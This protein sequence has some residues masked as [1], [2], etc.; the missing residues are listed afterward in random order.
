[1]WDYACV[2]YGIMLVWTVGL[3]LCAIAC[4]GR[5]ITLVWSV[6]LCLCGAWDYACVERGNMLVWGVGLC[7]LKLVQSICTS[8]V[9]V[10]LSDAR[11]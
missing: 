3:R 5:E 1:M 4:V 2:R 7:L 9:T 8:G 11:E 10:R 6:G